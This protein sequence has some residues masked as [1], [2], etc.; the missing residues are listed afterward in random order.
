[1]LHGCFQIISSV[2]DRMRAHD[3]KEQTAAKWQT[4]QAKMQ[5]ADQKGNVSLAELML[6]TLLFIKLSPVFLHIQ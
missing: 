1:M 6:E 2:H 4:M 3:R 5:E